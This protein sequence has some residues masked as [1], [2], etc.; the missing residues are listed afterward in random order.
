MNAPSLPLPLPGKLQ[1]L[2][3]EIAAYHRELPRLLA[4]GHRGR[5]VLV[6]GNTVAGVWDTENDAYQAGVELFG[7][8]PFL[9]QPI[10]ERDIER[11]APYVGPGGGAA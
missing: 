7:F 11:L 1:V 3:A 8:G 4:D 9:A 5:V 6:R 2:A 10:D